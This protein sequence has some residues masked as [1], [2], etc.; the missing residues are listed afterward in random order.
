[1]L[2]DD[3][4]IVRTNKQLENLSAVQRIEWALEKLLGEYIVTSSFGI[5]AA[6]MLHMTTRIM[7]EIK[8]VLLDTGYLFPET[9][10]FIDHLVDRLKLNL[11]VY[12][13]DIS[14][15]WQ[16]HRYGQLWGHGKSGLEQYN[17]INKVEPLQR[18][19]REN[20]VGCWF[21]ALR[22][23]QSKSRSRLPVLQM[24][25]SVVKVYP[26]VDWSHRDVHRYLN[27]HQLPYNPLWEKGYV[28][29]GDTHSTRPLEPG[30]SEEDT[31][32]FGLKRECGIHE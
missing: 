28:S 23:Q 2:I 14:P 20:N 15:A 31:R 32:F 5:Q 22:R 12:R 3:I 10:G 16:E 1:M 30:M 26:V 24:K 9:Y 7:P 25:G 27:K 4:S 18:A 17:H 11:Q 6:L 19:L 29:L 13:G 21:S 8:I